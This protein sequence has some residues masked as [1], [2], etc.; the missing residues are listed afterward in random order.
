MEVLDYIPDG[1][2]P[3]IGAINNPKGLRWIY[4]GKSRFDPDYKSAL[5]R[6]ELVFEWHDNQRLQ[7]DGDTK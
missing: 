5:V 7:K 4:N 3:R 1:W 2:R 6:E